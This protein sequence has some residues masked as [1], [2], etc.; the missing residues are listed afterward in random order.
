MVKGD[1]YGNMNL[2]NLQEKLL[3]NSHFKI[4]IV[5][6]SATSNVTS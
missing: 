4:Q 6:I 2:D 1:K 3:E 5:S